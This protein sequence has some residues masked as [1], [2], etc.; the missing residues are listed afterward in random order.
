MYK[1]K[2]EKFLHRV[3]SEEL[4]EILLIEDIKFKPELLELAESSKCQLKT[5]RFL[6]KYHD[7]SSS[8]YKNRLIFLIN[9]VSSTDQK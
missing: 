6:L 8:V 3:N 9:R 7:I 1:P 2:I 5:A 4:R